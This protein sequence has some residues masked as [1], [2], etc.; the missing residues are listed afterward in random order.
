MPDTWPEIG[1]LFLLFLISAVGSGP[2]PVPLT[3]TVLWLGQFHMSAAVVVVATLGS[4]IG[5][6]C[7]SGPLKRWFA[8]RPEIAQH[9]PEAYQQYFLKRTGLWVFIFNAVPLPFEPMRF[10]AVMN[11]YDLRKLLLAQT[12]GRVIRYIILVSLGEALA[13]HKI[14]L[15]SILGVVMLLPLAVKQVLAWIKRRV[16]ESLQLEESSKLPV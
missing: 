5:W 14:L 7:M 8:K 15:W 10:L 16:P 9:I 12:S 6:A 4:A 13:D 1:G 3:A 2:I 11:G